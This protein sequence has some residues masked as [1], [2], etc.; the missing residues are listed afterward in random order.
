MR[1]AT[2]TFI[3]ILVALDVLALGIIIPVLPK[4]VERFMGGDTARAA[5]VFGLFGTAWSLMQ[6]FFMPLLGML[7]D[8]FGRRPVI[9]ISCLG[10]GL[11]YFFMA[12]AP[13]LVLL[14]IGRLIS[15]I[16]AA[17]ISTAFAYIADVTPPEKRAGAFGMI[18]AAFGLG[19]VIGPA[20]GGVLGSV[21][22]RLPFWVAGAMAILN[23][24]Y[25]LFV[26][27][28]SLPPEKRAPFNWKR[29]NPLGSLTLLRSHKELFGLAS[30]LFLMNLAHMVLPSVAVL[31]MGYRYGWGELAVG[32][33]LAGVGVFAVIV[34]GGLMKPVVKRVGE[35]MAMTIGLLFGTV[36][37]VIYGLAPTGILFLVAVP[38]MS[39]WGFAAPSAQALM[40]KHV[41]PSE[42]G[43]LQGATASLVSIAGIVGPGLFTQ[44][45]AMTITTF[46][47]AA[48]V[49][50]GALLLAAATVGWRVTK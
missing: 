36:G 33:V 40:T 20:L 39:L 23:A 18:G 44:T 45:F 37:F 30:V 28:E 34:Q 46:P 35:R 3:F 49:M 15:G 14:F 38:I 12:L 31:Y 8:R 24:A 10:M 50:A 26:L 32:L 13:S 48:F 47:G 21:D 42:Q 2:L 4:L 16:T 11:D 6:F 25:G 17:S 5:E 41:G 19:F 29:A 1:K 43:Q 22:P 7:S 9:L 27:P